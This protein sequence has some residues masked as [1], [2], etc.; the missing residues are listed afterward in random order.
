MKENNNL[1]HTHTHT[2]QGR[3]NVWAGE[4]AQ[5]LRALAAPPEEPTWQLTTVYNFCSKGSDSLP[6]SGK[7]LVYM[8]EKE[9]N[10][11]YPFPCL[12]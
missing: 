8:K 2:F 3:N 10:K 4:M 1:T 12:N 11:Q 7:T 6:H 5:Q 9:R